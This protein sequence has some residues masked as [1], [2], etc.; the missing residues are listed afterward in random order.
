MIGTKQTSSQPTHSSDTRFLAF[1][2][3]TII[4]EGYRRV[5]QSSGHLLPSAFPCH[6]VVLDIPEALTGLLGAMQ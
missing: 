4:Q 1:G 6:G 5:V 3:D 2:S